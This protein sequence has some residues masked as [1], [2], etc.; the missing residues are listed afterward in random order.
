MSFHAG[1]VALVGRPNVGKSTL[2]NRMV[3]QRKAIVEDLAGTTRDRLYGDSDWNG[4]DFILVDTGGLDF[5][6]M[7]TRSAH[8]NTDPDEA[9]A[10]GY[11]AGV[12]SR[13]FLREIREQ[14]EIAMA[15]AEVIV[16][17]VDAETGVTG[18]DED[19]ADLLRRTEKPVILAVNKAD[20][21]KRRTDALEFYALGLG[22]PIPVSAL[23]GA[24]TGDLLDAVVESFPDISEEPEEDDSIKIALLGRP[25]VGKSSLLNKMLGE[26]RVIVSDVPGTTRDAIDTRIEYEDLEVVLID[27]AG[28][29]RRGKIE[30]GVEKHSFL[31]SLKAIDRADVC[32]LLIDAT[33]MVTLQDAH[34][35]GYILEKN[36]SVVVIVNKW[37]LIEKD[38]Y[39]MHE[40]TIQIR[41]GLKFLDF[42]PVLFISAKT[43]QR[44]DKVLPLA[45]QVQEERLRRI[46]TGEL[47]RLMHEAVAK[48]PPKGGHR[49]RLKFLYATQART[50]PPTFVFFVNDRKL[51]H[52]TYERY[53]E[54]QLR[55][56]YSFL[57]TPTLMVFRSRK[58]KDV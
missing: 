44:V 43:G 13:L 15:E 37:D 39:T 4:R 24:G 11:R 17:L 26:E 56:K 8:K 58:E 45:L 6:M 54:N 1:H 5:G 52:F 40:F 38:T 28:I 53:L 55:D 21:H 2:F 14:A 50:D 10:A 35:A 48:H 25:N 12:A 19:I 20:N 33:E 36:K 9:M 51:V 29:R 23:H 34:I 30:P 22:D 47:N 46:P 7:S 32:L 27:T 31:R 3:G 42:V 49:H 18:P 41:A 16:F 57:G